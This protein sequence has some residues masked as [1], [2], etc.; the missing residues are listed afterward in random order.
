MNCRRKTSSWRLGMFASPL[1]LLP[2]RLEPDLVPVVEERDAA[3]AGGTRA[4]LGARRG[5][6]GRSARPGAG[7]GRAMAGHELGR[8]RGPWGGSLVG[9]VVGWVASLVEVALPS[10][11]PLVP[12]QLPLVQLLG[13]VLG[14]V[15]LLFPR[16]PR[17]HETSATSGTS[18]SYGT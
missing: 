15:L 4:A 8:I 3:H 16:V 2:V 9:V 14:Q 10:S 12:V 17:C 6:S 1:P 13:Q 5:R 18:D 7:A 11:L